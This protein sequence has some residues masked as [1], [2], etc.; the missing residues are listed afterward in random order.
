VPK[1]LTAHAPTNTAVSSELEKIL[2]SEQFLSAG[3]LGPFL[4]YV[5]DRTIAGEGGTLKEP[6]VGVAVFGRAPDYDPRTD[7]IVRV[8]ARRLRARLDEYYKSSGKDDP[9]VIELPKGTYAPVF[10]TGRQPPIPNGR[11]SLWLA[12][13]IGGVV[14]AAI[15]WTLTRPSAVPDKSVAVLPFVNLSA[16]ASNEYFS[17]GLTDELI[18][19]LARVPGLRVVARSIVFQHKGKSYDAR[20]LGR[21]LNAATVVEGS[22]RR[23]GERIRITAQVV[24]AADGY[25]M[26]SRTYERE[27]NDVFAIQE[28]IATSIVNALRVELGRDRKVLEARRTTPEA[29]NEYLQARYEINRFSE[30]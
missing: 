30:E 7:P 2:A 5:V 25:E 4:R 21:Q 22:V 23:S 1:E 10:R 11:G 14:L 8:E 19:G 9:V 18:A 13:L 12:V 26:W 3:R 17:D 29:Y 24:N 16:D 15:L 6:V 20:A 28:E 27:L